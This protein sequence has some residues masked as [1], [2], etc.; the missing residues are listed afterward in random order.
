VAVERAPADARSAWTMLWTFLDDLDDTRERP[1]P[2]DIAHLRDRSVRP[3]RSTK[4]GWRELRR[5][6]AT[7]K[8]RLELTL[9]SGVA[10]RSRPLD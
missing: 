4:A 7:P 6:C 3:P 1:F 10:S 9:R 5:T 8:R 2:M